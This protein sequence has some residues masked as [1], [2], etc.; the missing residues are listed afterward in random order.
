[1]TD[2]R[3]VIGVDGGGSK[4]EVVWIRRDGQILST[5]RTSGSN[6]QDVGIEGVNELL[7]GVLSSW[8]RTA[9]REGPACICLGLAGA[10]RPDE[11][12]T[13][14]ESL[15]EKG[16]A[17]WVRV[18]TDARVALAGAHGGKGGI[19]AIAGT[20]SIVFGMGQ[21]GN[22]V[23][24]GGWGPLLGDEAGAYDIAM[25]ALRTVLAAHD[26]SGPETLLSRT[27]LAEL[28]LRSWTELVGRVY[29]GDLDRPALA[30][31]A[32]TILR[33]AEGGD[34][35][36]VDVV[37]SA[38]EGL[39]GQIAAV[40]RR[41]GIDR[42]DA[43]SYAG[44][45]LTGSSMLRAHVKE[46]LRYKG[47]RMRLR[48]ARLPPVLGAVLLAWDRVGSPLDESEIDKLEAVATE[49]YPEA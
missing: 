11:Q 18:E 15:L 46:A 24:A 41:L 16:W 19:I 1:M 37:R 26:G 39:A 2:E 22:W 5:T 14:A 43:L 25:R 36:A 34:R 28:G 21:N 23:R 45:L 38:A 7:E 20:G 33:C 40:T 35:V 27:L 42:E 29:G 13:I 31:L 30:Q 10:G 48:A 47:V 9:N 44:G 8:L 4:T 6:Y 49:L 17:D 32:P 12:R 3:S